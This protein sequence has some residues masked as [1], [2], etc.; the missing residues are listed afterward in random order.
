MRG[1]EWET[2][3]SYTGGERELGR[4]QYQ[5]DLGAEHGTL[6]MI[7]IKY[8]FRKR[9]FLKSSFDGQ[10]TFVLEGKICILQK[11]YYFARQLETF[12]VGA[13]TELF[14][15]D[16]AIVGGS[17]IY[18]YLVQILLFT[19]GVF[20]TLRASMHPYAKLVTSEP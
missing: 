19:K 14:Q 16:R 11:L 10:Y 1:C 7:L 12:K 3:L 15:R 20:E 5:T 9:E 13:G 8:L 4:S 2:F 6:W 18:E 17:K